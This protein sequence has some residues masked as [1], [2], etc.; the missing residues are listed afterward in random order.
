MTRHFLLI[1]D[2]APDY[3]ERRGDF[4]AAHLRYA[5]DAVKRQEL[6]VAGACAEPADMAVFHFQ[7]ENEASVA[8]FAQNDPYVLEGLVRA[9]RVRPWATVVGH[10]A[11][12]P[13]LPDAI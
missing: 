11:A 4:R 13:V 5:W 3:F 9:W 1:Y 6:I 10:G 7:G 8:A 12:T 2:L